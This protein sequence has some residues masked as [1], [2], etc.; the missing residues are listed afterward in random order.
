MIEII[1]QGHGGH[2]SV[3]AAKLLAQA[4][5]KS[6]LNA[7][8][9]ASYGAL[10]RG[11]R[12][13]GYVRISASPLRLR[14]KMY[15][16]DFLVLM[17]ESLVDES[18][19]RLPLRAKGSV[20][21]N[22]ARVAESFSFLG[23]YEVLTVDAYLIAREKGLVIPGGM[24]VINTCLLGALLG[25][26]TVVPIE[27]LIEAIKE[28]T[29]NPDKNV[30]CAMEGFRNIVHRAGERRERSLGRDAS[31]RKRKAR[32]PLHDLEKMVKCH[33]CMVC[34]IVCPNLAISFQMDPWA[35]GV[36]KN[37]CTGCGICIEE[38]PR[39]AISWEG[40]GS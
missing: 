7:Q 2:G 19:G 30:E 25:K 36:I 1:F 17:D 18:K 21:I 6:G 39:N 24:P 9:F 32:V 38:C 31:P 37:R 3:V 14:C 16:S 4:A 12:V 34:Y 27:H 11:G 13:E 8:S 26:M 22:T 10:R 20:L 28:N 35:L 23:S 5:A 29:P 33:R 40:V 15:E